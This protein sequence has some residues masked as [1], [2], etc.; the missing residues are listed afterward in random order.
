M[1]T[2][3]NKMKINIF[4]YILILIAMVVAVGVI[5]YKNSTKTP[6]KTAVKSAVKT[7][8]KTATPTNGLSVDSNS[9]D[10]GQLNTNSSSDQSSKNSSTPKI[11]DPS[12]FK[13]YESLV[14]ENKLYKIDINIGTGDLAVAGKKVAVLY[15]GWLTNGQVFDQ[16]SQNAEGKYEPLVFTPGAGQVIAGWEQGVVGMKVGGTRRLIIPPVGAYGPDGTDGIPPNSVLIFDIQLLEV[17]K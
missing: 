15:K 4:V 10:L 7:N 2:L 13:Q 14:N 1:Y 5:I 6:T 9:L 8:D 16:S 3:V 11:L 12:E 17:E